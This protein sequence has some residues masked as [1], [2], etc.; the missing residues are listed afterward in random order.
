MGVHNNENE[1]VLPDQLFANILA[2]LNL[3]QQVYNEQQWQLSELQHLQKEFPL[4]QVEGH[5]LHHRQP[6]VPTNNKLQRKILW[7]YHDYMMAGHLGITNT[8]C[9]VLHD[10]WWPACNNLPRHMCEDA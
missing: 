9:A 1:T 3:D 4:N 5:F 7:Q 6:V 2:S 10:Y 8:L